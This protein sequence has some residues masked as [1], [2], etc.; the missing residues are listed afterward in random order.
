MAIALYE[1][2]ENSGKTFIIANWETDNLLTCNVGVGAFALNLTMNLG[3]AIGTVKVRDWC[4]Q[5]P[6]IKPIKVSQGLTKW[7]SARRKG[8]RD[9]ALYAGQ[10]FIQNVVVAD[11]VEF[12]SVRWLQNITPTTASQWHDSNGLAL[13]PCKGESLENLPHC[14]N[15]LDDIIPNIGPV[16]G[17]VVQPDPPDYVLWSAWEGIRDD[18]PNFLGFNAAPPNP[19]NPTP[20]STGGRSPRLDADLA[21]LKARFPG[22]PGVPQLMVGEFG[23]EGDQN[24]SN[25][26]DAFLMG[27]LARSVQRAQL[28]VNIAWRAYDNSGTND[29]LFTA[30]GGEKTGMQV[31]RSALLAGAAE[32]AQPQTGQIAGIVVTTTPVSGIWYDLFEIYGTFQTPPSQFTLTCNPSAVI[33]EIV[34][35]PTTHQIN[36]RMRH[37]NYARQYCSVKLPGTRTHG[38]KKIWP[39][40]C[41]TSQ[42]R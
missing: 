1:T 21:D 8:I 33:P 39:G 24:L 12:T 7:F 38:P 32:L 15:T 29:G 27:E 10:R 23:G 40:Q 11:G 25:S 42:C 19:A 35:T 18:F 5:Q 20:T 17:G 31:L 4:E 41:L 26:Q 30:S 22:G 37:Q 28:P 34:G 3:P 36:I 6:D 2:Q 13:N 14:I 9:A 16:V